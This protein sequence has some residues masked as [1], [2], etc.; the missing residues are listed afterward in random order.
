MQTLLKLIIGLLLLVVF[1]V[2]W[3]FLMSV[4][5]TVG[6][7]IFIACFCAA[8]AYALSAHIKRE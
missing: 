7:A 2:G 3:I 4:P 1:A 6:K 8:V 5:G